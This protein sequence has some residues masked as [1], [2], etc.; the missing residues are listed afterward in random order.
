MKPNERKKYW[1]SSV[2]LQPKVI[3]SGPKIPNAADIEEMHHEAHDECFIANSVKTDIQV[4][5][6]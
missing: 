2:T 4:R 5:P 1:V 6:Q 3:F